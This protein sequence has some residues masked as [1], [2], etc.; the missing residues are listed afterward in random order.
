MFAN[1]FPGIID[2]VPGTGVLLQLEDGLRQAI[3]TTMRL[4]LQLNCSLPSHVTKRTL[5]G[6]CLDLRSTRGD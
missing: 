3:C 5:R 1:N 2:S 6:P 4:G